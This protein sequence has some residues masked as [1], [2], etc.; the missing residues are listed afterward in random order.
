M[1]KKGR[2]RST[3]LIVCTAVAATL[4]AASAQA[5]EQV[6][7]RGGDEFKP[8]EYV[9]STHRFA[10]GSI[11]VQPNEIVTWIDADRAPDPHTITFV[12]RRNLPDRLSE[13]FN[14]TAC[15]FANAHLSDPNDPNSP[16]ARRKVNVGKPGMN[17]QGDSL[18]LANRGRISSR[19]T[20]RLGQRIHYLCAI[21]PWMQG[22]IR[23]ARANPR[24]GSA[25]ASAGAA[26]AGRPR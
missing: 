17:T 19:I 12:F 10:P 7:T 13:I 23:V 3:A 24:S 11:T 18:Y 26:L 6:R 21:H 4:G 1:T 16:I 20:A 25:G 22:S 15:A 14:C 5:A 8:N 9:R 2:R